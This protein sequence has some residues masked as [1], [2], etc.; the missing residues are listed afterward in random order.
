MST[1]STGQ[2]FIAILSSKR[3][4]TTPFELDIERDIEFEMSANLVDPN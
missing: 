2:P 1:V 3:K 4:K